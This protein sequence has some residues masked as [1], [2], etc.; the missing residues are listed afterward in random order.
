MIKNISA[1]FKFESAIEARLAAGKMLLPPDGLNQRV[2][3]AVIADQQLMRSQVKRRK[4]AGV[5]AFT[6]GT[7]ALVILT[8][9]ITTTWS[10]VIRH[11][12][13]VNPGA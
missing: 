13:H 9:T 4:A 8:V 11:F 12:W 2:L 3:R 10:A 5:A 6:I 7:A 1:H